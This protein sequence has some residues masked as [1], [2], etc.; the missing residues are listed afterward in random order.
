[1]VQ[2]E[3]RIESTDRY[4]THVTITGPPERHMDSIVDR[5]QTIIVAYTW[6]IPAFVT[7]LGVIAR[8][9]QLVVYA[10]LKAKSYIF[11]SLST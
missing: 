5:L 2:P 6:S 3:D 11:K 7:K 9:G 8:S 4:N 1:M 10:L